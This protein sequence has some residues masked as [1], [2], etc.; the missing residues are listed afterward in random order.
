MV[1]VMDTDLPTAH[2]DGRFISARVSRIVE[3]IR[4]YDRRLNVVWIP[5]DRR[6]ATDPA[7]AITERLSDGRVVIAFYVQN[8]ESFNES[9]L[10]RVYE[11]DTT[12]NDVQARIDA[13]NKA[14]RAIQARRHEEELADSLDFMA[15][16]FKTKKHTFK[17]GG[18]TLHL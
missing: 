17:H 14:A 6:G 9:V 13:K 4:E 11:G 12:R 8:E 1:Y 15:T 16:M 7:F 5:P 3:L 2:D 10:A 18:R